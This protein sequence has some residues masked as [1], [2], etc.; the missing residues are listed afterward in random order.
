[1][2]VVCLALIKVPGLVDL[3]LIQ[4]IPLGRR[5]DQVHAV[6]SLRLAFQHRGPWPKRGL[7]SD[8]QAGR[9]ASSIC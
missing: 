5:S 4:Q 3:S 2:E 6:P 7:T 9:Q 8:R 1:M